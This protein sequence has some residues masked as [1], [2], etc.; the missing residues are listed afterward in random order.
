MTGLDLGRLTLTGG[1]AVER[2]V[3]HLVTR[4]ARVVIRLTPHAALK[5]LVLAGG[6]GR[7][8]GG[9]RL[10]EEGER[11]ANNLDLIL[12]TIGLRS[13]ERADLT[14]E[15]NR[16][17]ETL[18]R[19]SGMGIDFSI[20]DARRLERDR[21][22]VLWYDVRHGHKLL[23]G[24]PEF[25]SGLSRFTV[26]NIDP[27]EM[28]D[29]LINRGALLILNDL[30]FDRGTLTSAQRETAVTH[31]A[32]AV[33][34]YGDALLFFQGLYDWSYVERRRRMAA[35]ATRAT[36]E[37]KRLYE[38]AMTYRFTGDP[39]VGQWLLNHAQSG[40]IRHLLSV[41]H[42]EIEGLRLRSGRRSWHGYVRG[43]LR[44]ELNEVTSSFSKMARGA[45]TLIRGGVNLGNG[46][47]YS[48]RLGLRA[49]G[50]QGA[51]RALFPLAAYGHIDREEMDVARR[52][53]GVERV[54]STAAKAAWL[55]MWGRVFDPNLPFTL[56]RLGLNVEA[57][58]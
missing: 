21:V 25:L 20:V 52:L 45:L 37:F 38:T 32:K 35:R 5:S 27:R 13:A 57:A 55:R 40:H 15:V 28:G 10:D 46:T 16:E 6:Y 1:T 39:K 44:R 50:D 12:F 26:S 53:L 2:T 22:R 4:A 51:V 56:R 41:L 36:P 17:L 49:S 24:D 30:L 42:L 31:I 34:G 47:A 14:E 3:A 58:A 11:P 19:R 18:R 9:V 8:E 7:G 33:I 54:R 48:V 29:L 43:S 23:A